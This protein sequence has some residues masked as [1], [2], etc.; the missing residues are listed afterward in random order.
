M[1]ARDLEQAA[2]RATDPQGRQRPKDRARRLK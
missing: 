2:A 1:R